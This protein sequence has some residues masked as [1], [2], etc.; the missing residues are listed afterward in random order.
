[1]AI[2]CVTLNVTS[3]ESAMVVGIEDKD[4]EKYVAQTTLPFH[5]AQE[6]AVGM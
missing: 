3:E 2:G 1:M 5:I 4:V 6:V